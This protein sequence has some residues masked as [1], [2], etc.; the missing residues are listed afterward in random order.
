[1]VI[2]YGM[3][4]V[5]TTK[6]TDVHRLSLYFVKTLLYNVGFCTV[7]IKTNRFQCENSYIYNRTKF[8]LF[9]KCLRRFRSY[10]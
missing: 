10:V 8:N 7:K 5:E 1:M 4:I 2:N 6:L 3:N 9:Q